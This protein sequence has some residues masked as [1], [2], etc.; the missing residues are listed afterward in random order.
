MPTPG[1]LRTW[2][3][4]GRWRLALG[5][6]VVLIAAFWWLGHRGARDQQ[7]ATFAARRGPLEINVIEG[8]SFQALESLEIK[9]EV[10]VGFQGL[11]I[12]KIVEEGYLV[13]EE[14]IRTNKA[15]VELD[16]SELKKQIVQQDISYESA[17]AR[18][19]KS[20]V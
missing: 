5:A 13:T 14:D 16:S 10:R 2:L 7:S 6:A 3:G 11:K 18:D 12:L 4:G 19:R 20:V 17:L 15:L 9:C 8:G 1:K